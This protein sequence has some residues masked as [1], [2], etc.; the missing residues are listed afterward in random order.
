MVKNAA[1]ND[2][3]KPGRHPT[4][5]RVDGVGKISPIR[6]VCIVPNERVLQVTRVLSKNQAVACRCFSTVEV[7]YRFSVRGQS[8]TS[9]TYPGESEVAA[10]EIRGN[11]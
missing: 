8:A 7:L 10:F 1:S 5:R 11:E 6:V 9:G 4:V 3:S 2:A